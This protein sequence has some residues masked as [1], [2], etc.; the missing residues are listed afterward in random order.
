[1]PMQDITALPTAPARTDAP[2][3]FIERADAFVAAL[4]GLVTEINTLGD[5]LELTAALINAAPAYAD[6]GLVALAGLTPA[7]DKVPYWT[8][9]TTSA[10]MTITSAARS[11]LDDTTTAAMLTTLGVSAFAQTILDDANAVAVIATLG[12]TDHVFKAGMIM[13]W[14]GSIASIPAG[15]VICDG[16]SGTPDLR[17]KFVVGAGSTYAV[18]ATGGATTHDHGGVTGSHTLTTSEIPAHS[19]AMFS[20]NL[21][22]T[23]AS[24]ASSIARGTTN[25][26]GE[27][28]YEVTTGSGTPT[29]GVTADAGSGSGHD[30]TV[31]SGSSLP[32]YYALA[33][34]MKT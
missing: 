11:I 7:A 26:P 3:V 18:G 12:I 15:W 4:P 19:H 5:Q 16:T 14:S 29:I 1:M 2:E 17:D 6:A 25:S 32:P 21:N 20:N 9:S 23:P 33:Y 8:S 10:T 30:H 22:D 31:A 24:G 27:E 28:E 34:I 13:L